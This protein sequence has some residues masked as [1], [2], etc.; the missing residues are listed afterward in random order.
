MKYEVRLS[1][2]F[3][4]ELIL[5]SYLSK[6]YALFIVLNFYQN[7]NDNLFINKKKLFKHVLIFSL[8]YLIILL[9]GERAAF[10]FINLF[11]IIFLFLKKNTRFI[12]YCFI[13][14]A[15]TS[16]SLLF[17]LNEGLKARFVDNF[18]IQ[19]KIDIKNNKF[20]PRD[21]AGFFQTSLEIYE[22][23]KIIGS[24]VRTFRY[25]CNKY[26][27]IISNSCNNHPHNYF[28]EILSETGSIGI[29]LFIIFI[30]Y[31]FKNFIKYSI[32]CKNQNYLAYINLYIILLFQPIM[33][34]G[35][36][37]N[38]WNLCLNSFLISIAVYSNCKKGI[39]KFTLN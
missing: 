25:E 29:L 20:F 5:G 1:S 28:F 15:I 36:F 4:D 3:G 17:N 38:N 24:G 31:F 39:H 12:G 23:N 19:S 26:Q 21:Y 33:T 30:L 8:V 7:N 37:F 32:S 2:F 16:C 22:S 6:I 18:K 10:I 14:V 34:T 11:I 9:T 35:S 27:D 13:I